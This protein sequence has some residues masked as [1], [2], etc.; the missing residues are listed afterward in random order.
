MNSMTIA[1]LI[2]Y[3]GERELLRECLES[4]RDQTSPPAEILV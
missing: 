1:V 4:L 3:Y 2:T